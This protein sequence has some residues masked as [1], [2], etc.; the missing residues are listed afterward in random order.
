MLHGNNFYLWSVLIF[1]FLLSFS[2]EALF[3]CLLFFHSFFFSYSNLVQIPHSFR[4]VQLGISLG[5]SAPASW[6]KFIQRKDWLCIPVT[7]ISLTTQYCVRTLNLYFSPAK[8][9]Y[10]SVSISL[11]FHHLNR[12][13][14]ANMVWFF[15]GSF[16]HCLLGSQQPRDFP[17][18]RNLCILFL[19]RK[20]RILVLWLEVY[21]SPWGNVLC[22]FCPRST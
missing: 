18:T 9:I 12:L 8:E 7:G 3:I 20:H 11:P 5:S 15:D 21:S 1:P 4:Q 10:R 2:F 6:M 13:L 14:N 16:L 19:L 17:T 22:W